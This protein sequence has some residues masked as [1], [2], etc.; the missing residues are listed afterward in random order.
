[1]TS[2]NPVKELA[3]VNAMLDEACACLQYL[4][5]KGTLVTGAYQIEMYGAE[6]HVPVMIDR[7]SAKVME[8][9]K[10]LIDER[11]YAELQATHK[12]YHIEK[13]L[14]LINKAF[15]TERT[16]REFDVI[17]QIFQKPWPDSEGR[18]YVARELQPSH[19]I[20]RLYYDFATCNDYLLRS[21]KQQE[22]K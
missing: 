10:P 14:K 6:Q 4:F 20:N 1:M 15:I 12:Y 5:D 7:I 9:L 19:R 11:D 21:Q 2:S 16:P 18:E 17:V 8:L 3:T 22:Q 13:G